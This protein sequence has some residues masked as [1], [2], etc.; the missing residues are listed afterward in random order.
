[1][2]R[3]R[4]DFQGGNVVGIFPCFPR[5]SWGDLGRIQNAKKIKASIADALLM[6][7]IF[8]EGVARC[9][10]KNL[11]L[12]PGFRQYLLLPERT[13]KLNKFHCLVEILIREFLR[14]GNTIYFHD[15]IFEVF[16]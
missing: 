11:R 6:A 4:D 15:R 10:S 9:D 2:Y 13:G 14:R 3:S 5:N 8:C 7:S 16:I 12:S 1:V